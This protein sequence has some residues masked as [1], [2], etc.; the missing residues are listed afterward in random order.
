M[1]INRKAV[2]FGINSYKLKKS[3]K[4]F[5]K[6]TKP[7]GIILFS[8]NIKSLD[9]LKDLVKDIKIIFN[10]DKYPILIDVE[11]GKVSRLNKIID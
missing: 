7:W 10:D 4:I 3:E 11:G 1:I 6:R 5:F 8:R 9:Q 2:I